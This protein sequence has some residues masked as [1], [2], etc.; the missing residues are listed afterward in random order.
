MASQDDGYL[1][2]MLLLES[3]HCGLSWLLILRKR[4]AFRQAFHG[5]SP[6]IIAG[7]GPEEVACLMENPGIVRNESKIRATIE[8]ARSFLQIQEEFGSFSAYL[9]GFTQNQVQYYPFDGTTKRNA[10]S[11]RVAKDLKKRGFRFMG[12]VTTFSYLEA[13]GVMNNHADYCCCYPGEHPN[14]ET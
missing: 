11:D 9:W 5:F 8:N 12:S 10:L 13:V 6:E 4:E 2:E 3:F 1:F 14:M 7:Y